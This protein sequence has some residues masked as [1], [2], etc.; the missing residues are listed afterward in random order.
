M[1]HL[2][3]EYSR[4]LEAKLDIDALVQALHEVASNIEALPV[5]GIRTRAVARDYYRIADCDADNLF[6]HLVLRIAP[7][8]PFELRKE[9]GDTI[10]AALCK[11]LEP[12]YSA[13]PLAISF[14]V[15]ELDD[16]FRWKQNNLRD[17]MSKRTGASNPG[18]GA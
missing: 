6:V 3:V 10:F 17:Y 18:S 7:G 11:H 4:N 13:A 5:A 16:D 12:V 8:R 2:T 15:Q 1:P 14:E 9:I